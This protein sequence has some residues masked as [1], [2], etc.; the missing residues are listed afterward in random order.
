MFRPIEPTPEEKERI[1][2][3]LH[4]PA[5]RLRPWRVGE[6][7]RVIQGPF[8]GFRGQVV[9]ENDSVIYTD[10]IVFGHRTPIALSAADVEPDAFPSDPTSLDEGQQS[11]IR[12]WWGRILAR[13]R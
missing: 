3:A 2:R 8:T 4:P 5:V 9:A 11:A 12:S 1:L 10:L 7:L 6:N 13:L